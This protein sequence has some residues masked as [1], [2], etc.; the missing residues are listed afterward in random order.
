M[1]KRVMRA[2]SLSCLTLAQPIDLEFAAYTKPERTAG[3]K[4]KNTL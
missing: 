4:A 1:G 3:A 2:L